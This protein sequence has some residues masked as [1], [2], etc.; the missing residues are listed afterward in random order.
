MNLHDLS[1]HA[2]AGHVQELNLISLEGGIYILE[3]RMDDGAHPLSDNQ[4]HTMHLRSVEH[5]RELLHA[6]PTLPCNLVHTMVHDE[7][8]GI[9]EDNGEIVCVPISLS[10]PG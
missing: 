7:M 5:A 3:A 10:L 1:S 6:L 2:R 8:C 9:R 4:G